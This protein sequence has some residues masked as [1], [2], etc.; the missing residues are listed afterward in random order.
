MTISEEF[1]KQDWYP[2]LRRRGPSF[3]IMVTHAMHF[4]K[5][6]GL[7]TIIETGCARNED[8]WEGDGHSTYI[9]DWLVKKDERFKAHSIDIQQDSIDISKKKT[10]NVIYH[11]GDSVKTLMD[12]PKGEIITCGL[13]YLDSFDW[14]PNINMESSFHHMMELAAV[15]R[16]LPPGCLV[17]VDDRKGDMQG[18]HWM[19]GLFM[20]HIGLK[21]IFRNVQI[22]WIKP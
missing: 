11:L 17:A 3:D 4:L 16:D 12:M 8:N 7:C 22:G 9:W 10:T 18:K 19:V 15:W 2:R 5:T 1:K 6:H 14:A 21:P 13:L 20:E